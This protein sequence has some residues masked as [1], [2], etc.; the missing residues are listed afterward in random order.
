MRQKV[1]TDS[2]AV[3]TRFRPRGRNKIAKVAINVDPAEALR[4]V[5]APNG[6][7]VDAVGAVVLTVIVTACDPVPEITSDEGDT[8][9]VESLGAPLQ[10]RVTVPS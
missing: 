8:E 6:I 2:K 10:L 4:T 3:V 1:K 9:H 7:A 5:D